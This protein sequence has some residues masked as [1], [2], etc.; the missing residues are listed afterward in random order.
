MKSWLTAYHETVYAKHNEHQNNPITMANYPDSVIPVAYLD[1]LLNYDRH[2]T[3][4]MLY[5]AF[6]V[7]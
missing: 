4:M 5:N 7:A 1:I 3:V 2:L 6:R